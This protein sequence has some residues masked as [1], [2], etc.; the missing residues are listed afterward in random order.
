ML[1]LQKSLR[2]LLPSR[3]RSI[4][5]IVFLFLWRTTL[6][7]QTKT[8]SLPGLKATAGHPAVD[9]AHFSV[10]SDLELDGQCAGPLF[11]PLSVR[12][13]SCR[14][15]SRVSGT[16]R[17][18]HERAAIPCWADRATLGSFYCLARIATAATGQRWSV[19][20]IVPLKHPLVCGL[21]CPANLTLSTLVD[22]VLKGN[23]W[24]PDM[25]AMQAELFAGAV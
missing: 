8:I 23:R 15:G 6:N 22:N 20:H 21:H 12:K 9:L 18:R 5:R 1:Q 17:R 25:P 13:G 11:G 24:W 3:W 4:T 2:N 14:L 19:E 10:Q 7:P 16:H